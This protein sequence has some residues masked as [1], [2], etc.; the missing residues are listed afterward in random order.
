[1]SSLDPPNE[2]SSS[3]DNITPSLP[4]SFPPTTAGKFR[5]ALGGHLW[6][7]MVISVMSCYCLALLIIAMIVHIRGIRKERK[8]RIVQ[9]RNKEELYRMASEASFASTHYNVVEMTG[10]SNSE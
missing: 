1:M 6:W 9:R 2:T 8:I 10:D 4:S 3:H 5:D 7:I